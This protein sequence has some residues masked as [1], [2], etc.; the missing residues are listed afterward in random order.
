[1]QERAGINHL[2]STRPAPP[3]IADGTFTWLHPL[4]KYSEGEL[5]PQ[6]G[7]DSATYLYFINI[8]SKLFAFFSLVAVCV[9]FPI[10]LTGGALEQQTIKGLNLFS[11]SISNV[12][13]LDMLWVHVGIMWVFT[14]SSLFALYKVSV[15]YTALRHEYMRSEEYQNSL[16]ARAIMF[17]D[18]P[19]DQQTERGLAQLYNA[20]EIPH[21]FSGVAINRD[22]SSVQK[23]IEKRER[24][25][26]AMEQ[27]LVKKFGKEGTELPKERPKELEDFVRKIQS[28]EAE[29]IHE[30][31]QKAQT[32]KP[33]STGFITFPSVAIAQRVGR[34]L[35]APKKGTAKVFRAP[36]E[37]DIIW[38]NATMSEGVRSKKA[39]IGFLIVVGICF[40]YSIY[41]TFISSLANLSKISN[42]IPPVG[43]FFSNYPNL[44]G[45]VQAALPPILVAVSTLVLIIVLR[46]ISEF[47][48]ILLKSEVQFSLMRKNYA[49][50]IIQTF[51]VLNL[52]RIILTYY[53]ILQ[54]GDLNKFQEMNYADFF[55]ELSQFLVEVIFVQ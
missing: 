23:L 29:I 16:H 42:L 24:K 49:F 51:L 19:S 33:N 32:Y 28:L 41:T 11:F 13:K 17:V 46:K 36:P 20:F 53:N 1:M 45:V 34:A 8:F 25:V 44:A 55:K 30:R 37:K 43:R 3:K 15:M 52:S 9:L 40:T 14:F 12:I 21:K 26:I 4:V 6:L 7:L 50:Y 27:F 2:F 35:P 10:H 54:S 38:S 48:G 5:L 47:Q 39:M 31:Q 18:V 22:P